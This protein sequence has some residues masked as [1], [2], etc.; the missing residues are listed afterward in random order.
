MADTNSIALT[1]LT[2]AEAASRI[3]KGELSSEELVG[4]CLA[5]LLDHGIDVG[6]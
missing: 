3:A 2:V 1:A 5:R 6:G 4:A